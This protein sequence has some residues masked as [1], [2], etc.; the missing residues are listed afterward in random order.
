MMNFIFSGMLIFSFVFAVLTGRV[1]QLS[2]S[3]L[4]QAGNAV[5]L[6]LSLLGM[7]CLWGGIMRI[8]QESKLTEKLSKALSPVTGRLFRGLNRGDGR[9]A[10]SQ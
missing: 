4:K 1:D 7:L 3:V 5:E 6:V 9:C 8:A 2:Q 10:R